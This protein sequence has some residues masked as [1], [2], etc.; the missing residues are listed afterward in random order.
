MPE[1]VEFTEKHG[2]FHLRFSSLYDI[3]FCRKMQVF[4]TSGHL[5]SKEGNPMHNT[6][7][8]IALMGF[9]TVGGGV[10]E[11]VQGREDM[12]MRY[13]LDL[14]PC[15]EVTCVVT[16]NFDDICGDPEVDTV[17][18]TM[19]GLH[20]AYEYVKASLM[21]G[22]N[23]ITANKLLIAAHY[24]E[25]VELARQKGVALRCTAAAGGG[26]PWLI[27]IERTLKQEPI[28]RVSGIMNGTTNYILDTMHTTGG[29][30]EDALAQAQKLGYAEADP[31]A[32]LAGLD[33]R[34]K[35]V[36]S[37]NIAFGCVI[38][39]KDVDVWG[40]ERLRLQ[41][42]EACKRM[43]RVCKLIASARKLDGCVAAYIEPAFVPM[44]MHEAA[45]P[46][47]YNLIS[48]TGTHIGKQSFFGQGAG[49]Y[50][51]AYNVVQDC[52]DVAQGKRSFYTDELND[53]RVDNS[54]IL[55]RYYVRTSSI[56][57]WLQGRID[58]LLDHGIITKEVAVSDIHE[59]ARSRRETDPDCFIASLR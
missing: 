31:T 39:E 43:G 36:I 45:V 58:K 2:I 53:A 47:N 49:R 6:P 54:G 7:M 57:K 28:I 3:L 18:E 12:E 55:R 42:I 4:F 30:F 8:R 23:V 34:R 44:T 20:P 25:L 40:I 51:T 50:P 9:G 35:I 15:P 59:W 27:N 1:K 33:I 11:F 17:I 19:G 32:D 56:D 38:D 37:A 16:K 48:L 26:I 24:R 13:V 22:K 52:L 29:S 46:G 41:D 5:L 10:Y 14:H 21:A